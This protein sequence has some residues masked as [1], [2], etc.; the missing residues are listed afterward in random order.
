MHGPLFERS[1]HVTLPLVVVCVLLAF[2]GK[3][4]LLNKR[5]GRAALLTTHDDPCLVLITLVSN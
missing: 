3:W 4:L 2:K 5:N 1:R